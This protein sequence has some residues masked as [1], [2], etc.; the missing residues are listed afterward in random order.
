MSLVKG[1]LPGCPQFRRSFSGLRGRDSP[2]PFRHHLFVFWFCFVPLN[3]WLLIIK[4]SENW[5]KTSSDLNSGVGNPRQTIFKKMKWL[6]PP[7]QGSFGSICGLNGLRACI[8]IPIG[9]LP[10]VLGHQ[11]LISRLNGDANGFHD[12]FNPPN[13]GF[14]SLEQWYQRKEAWNRSHSIS[15]DHLTLACIRKNHQQR[16]SKIG[17]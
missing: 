14:D 6:P 13:R 3:A 10:T 5:R 15:T 16:F 9:G 8:P 7:A 1:K 17:T 2:F 11:L 4:K 12:H